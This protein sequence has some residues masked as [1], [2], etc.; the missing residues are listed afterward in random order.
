MK[1]R[2]HL[3]R[4]KMRELG[5]RD[6]ELSHVLGVNPSA[7]SQRM[8]GRVSWRTGEAYLVLQYLGLPY[9]D[10]YY[11]FPPDGEN[12][13]EPRNDSE[14]IQKFRDLRDCLTAI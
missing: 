6:G 13:G 8:T 3:L 7:I 14:I 5:V 12:V 4:R 9:E 10:I 2:Y 11:Y 1:T